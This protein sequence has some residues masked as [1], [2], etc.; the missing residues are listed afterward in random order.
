MVSASK[1]NAAPTSAS[2]KKSDARA[3]IHL[4]IEK[5]AP[6]FRTKRAIACWQNNP[7]MTVG[8]KIVV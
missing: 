6:D 8:L 7:T 4:K 1:K 3:A 5:P 2:F